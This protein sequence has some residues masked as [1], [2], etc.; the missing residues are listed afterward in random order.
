[1]ECLRDCRVFIL[2]PTSA[3]PLRISSQRPP[4]PFTPS[5]PTDFLL[6]FGGGDFPLSLSL[7]FCVFLLCRVLF[8]NWNTG[9]HR[10]CVCCLS[11]CPLV[12]DVAYLQE[13]VG[14]PVARGLAE[15]IA[16]QPIDP[17]E[18]LGLYLKHED[19]LALREEK[20]CGS[21]LPSFFALILNVLLVLVEKKGKCSC[22]GLKKNS[23]RRFLICASLSLSLSLPFSLPS[24]IDDHALS[25]RHWFKHFKF[26]KMNFNRISALNWAHWLNNN[27]KKRLLDYKFR[28][29]RDWFLFNSGSFLHVL[30]NFSL[31]FSNVTFLCRLEVSQSSLEPILLS[32]SIDIHSLFLHFLL[33]FRDLYSHARRLFKSAKR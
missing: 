25:W 17:V 9:E 32:I 7:C 23:C 8:V 29:C 14:E 30:H 13:T 12:M 5:F 1:M 16:Q 11:P 10:C 33:C 21:F 4:T 18:Y 27:V 26:S 28:W 22:C 31:C 20:V 15:V 6:F 2:N 19:D 24:L 3:E